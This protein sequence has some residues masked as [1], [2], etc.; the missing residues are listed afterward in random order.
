M[1]DMDNLKSVNDALGHAAGDEL[2]HAVG[3]VLQTSI[4]PTDS[5]G[6]I[7]GDEFIV[8]LPDTDAQQAA[9][10]AD[11]LLQSFRRQLTE[12]QVLRNS[13]ALASAVGMSI[14]IAATT[15]GA[16]STKD[17]IARADSALYRA[18]RAGRSCSCAA[19]EPPEPAAPEP[20]E[21]K[22]VTL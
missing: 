13:P 12:H 20:P 10:I 5:A 16:A 21:E 14:G 19:E 4:H 15:N 11:R 3:E 6:R 9:L 22:A 8:L 2:L 7:G 17:L 18:K 1:I